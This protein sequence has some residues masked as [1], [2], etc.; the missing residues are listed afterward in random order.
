MPT[1]QAELTEFLE[2]LGLKVDKA[3]GGSLV[4]ERKTALSQ[5]EKRF[6]VDTAGTLRPKQR[7]TL[8]IP[9]G[10][11]A[12]PSPDAGEWFRFPDFLDRAIRADTLA[13]KARRLFDDEEVADQLTA[14][15]PQ[16]LEIP[17]VG[18]H[19]SSVEFFFEDWLPAPSKRLLVVLAPA[20]YGKT[21]LTYELSRRLGEAHLASE[22]PGR[23]PIPFLIP[24]GN[25]RRVADFEGMI[26]SA[27]SRRGIS[28]FTAQ[29]FAYLVS[30]R[31]VVL[32]LDGFDELL[33]E[34]PNEA[35]KNLRELIETLGGEGKVVLTARSTF[36]RTSVDVA[37]FLENFLDPA[38]V[39]VVELRPF[40]AARRHQ[41]LSS[42]ISSDSDRRKVERLVESDAIREAMGSPL[43]LRQVVDHASDLDLEGTESRR[44]L[45]AALERAVYQRE[46]V[47]HG[48]T[49]S[50]GR[51]RAMLSDLAGEMMFDN[52]RGFDM[53]SVQ[54]SALGALDGTDPEE[55]DVFRL[56]DHHFL[57]V[58][59]NSATVRFNHQVFREHFQATRLLSALEDSED[60]WILSVLALRHLPE[61]VVA[62][63]IELGDDDVARRLVDLGADHGIQSTQ[64]A[65]NLAALCAQLGEWGPIARLL[66]VTDLSLPVSLRL[67]GFNL[68]QVEIPA[69]AYGEVEIVDSELGG[70]RFNGSTIQRLSICNS[71]LDD[72]SFVDTSIESALFDFEDSV[73]GDFPVR[74]RLSSLGADAGLGE[75]TTQ[76]REAETHRDRIVAFVEGRLRRFYVP[77][78][79]GT[80][81]SKWDSAIQERNL[82][83]G[84]SQGERPWANRDVIPAM[85]RAGLITRTRRH[86]LIIYEL[87]DEAEDDARVLIE[88]G[89]VQGLVADAVD[90]LT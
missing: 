33:E 59:A 3:S 68:A 55:S 38:D 8:I 19:D 2:R 86:N 56:A 82:L 23:Q 83:G 81:G 79:S 62:G 72:A 51:Q 80:M 48:H 65:D 5:E 85:M 36:F 27:L 46:R 60:Q 35:Q 77:G 7:S 61:A 25:F 22:G 63:V 47:R 10:A 37:D 21:L 15:V 74:E 29:A 52:V 66:E 28:D 53:E 70:A 76:R 16:Q 31:R 57:T 67:R 43:L 18:V 32:F 50:D 12:P 42:V 49:I 64:L 24:F 17:G 20:G 54:A 45:F 40:D 88:D 34:R 84:L 58:D 44:E 41:F 87:A 13:E 71:T 39:E 26:L 11:P 30:Q 75:E 4:A 73:Y 9:D 90:R 78:P 89:I 69:R 6:Y 14:F 1:L